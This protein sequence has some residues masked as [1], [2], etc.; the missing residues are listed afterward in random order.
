M[1]KKGIAFPLWLVIFECLVY[2]ANDFALPAVPAIRTFFHVPEGNS[3]FFMIAWLFG[4]SCFH[5]PLGFCAEKFGY[6]SIWVFGT[7]VFVAGLA[8]AAVSHTIFLFNV[9]RMLQGMSLSAVFV[10]GYAWFHRC[11]ETQEAVSHLAWMGVFR[12]LPAAIGSF[13]G[14]WWLHH[15]TWQWIFL[16]LLFF[17]L[18]DGILV[19][20][21]LPSNRTLQKRQE[22]VLRYRA[23]LSQTAFVLP[24]CM[25]SLMAS[26][27]FIWLAHSPLILLGQENLADYTFARYQGLVFF[28]FGL[29]SWILHAL[30]RRW[31]LHTWVHFG[32]IVATMSILALRVVHDAVP[33][34]VLAHVACMALLFAG[35]AMMRSPLQRLVMDAVE[36]AS[37][38]KMALFTTITRLVSM[39]VLWGCEAFYI[40]WQAI[41]NFFV[42]MIGVLWLVWLKYRTV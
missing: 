8:L 9:A 35:F 26:L 14:V 22:T 33:H 17:V 40:D 34:Q 20:R 3:G 6:R 16:S 13:I 10:A 36:G 29:G 31:S 7:V 24:V 25:L 30:Q 38:K 28:G 27:V 21:H 18:I 5:I 12:L 15:S 23:L 42:V 1:V 11:Y 32:L 19:F 4:A 41:A 39:L 37:A 2:C